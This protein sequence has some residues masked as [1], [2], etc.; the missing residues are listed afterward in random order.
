M[1]RRK[2]KNRTFAICDKEDQSGH[3]PDLSR[4]LHV[5]V[6][7]ML[8]LRHPLSETDDWLDLEVAI[9]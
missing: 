8:V 2:G 3:R 4:A 9:G 6:D 7:Q 5:K 1:D